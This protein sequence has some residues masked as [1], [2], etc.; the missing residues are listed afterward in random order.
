MAEAN[1]YSLIIPARMV[2]AHLFTPQVWDEKLQKFRNP[3]SPDEDSWYD[4]T[5]L[6]DASG[7]DFNTI[8]SMAA[9]IYEERTSPTAD[10]R[11]LD[12]DGVVIPRS[13][14]QLPW[15]QG[16][17]YAAAKAAAGAEY[18]LS[19]FNGKM[20][21]KASTRHAPP[22]AAVVDGREE[23]FP[24]LKRPLAEKFIFAGAV[25]FAEFD[26]QP[27]RKGNNAPGIKAYL[28]A[29]CAIAGLGSRIGNTKPAAAR[30]N[31]T[32]YVG[33]SAQTQAQEPAAAGGWR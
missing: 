26:L 8:A 13:G 24:D 2:F 21:L 6:V 20:L 31:L 11:W 23:E 18:D 15:E 29:V 28:G 14:V 25:C 3:T 10:K 16:E 12:K 9:A 27:Y 4:A 1:R 32:G 30:F 17:R 5:F 7:Q 22:L 19:D 33:A